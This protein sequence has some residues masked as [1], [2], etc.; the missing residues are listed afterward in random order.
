MEYFV[1]NYEIGRIHVRPD[2]GGY[3]YPERLWRPYGVNSY[4]KLQQGR[5]SFGWN[6]IPGELYHAWAPLNAT[7]W[8]EEFRE[9]FAHW[10]LAVFAPHDLEHTH[11]MVPV[12]FTFTGIGSDYFDNAL[13]LHKIVN[14][15]DCIFVAFDTHLTGERH[16]AEHRQG[17]S[18]ANFYKSIDIMDD[19]QCN[20]R[21]DFF[22]EM[23]EELAFNVLQITSFLCQRFGLPKMPLC[24][25]LG[26][27][28]GG[29]YAHQIALQ[30][31]HCFG[32]VGGA[33][34]PDI[35]LYRGPYDLA[36]RVPNWLADTAKKVL[37]KINTPIVP[38][39]LASFA[40]ALRA[41]DRSPFNGPPVNPST[42]FHFIVGTRDYAF[43]AQEVVNTC[44]ALP[45]NI[46]G[47]I[48][49][50]GTHTPCEVGNAGKLTAVGQGMLDYLAHVI[51]INR[52]Y[53][54]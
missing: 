14:E 8:G 2:N 15:L 9:K 5:D 48:A 31:P 21:N 30:T 11:R 6:G 46:Y 19:K 12:V 49:E 38:P 16:L 25:T 24:Y 41:I 17:N 22:R 20:M 53:S 47:H 40:K 4:F 33:A 27:S 35:M 50:G 34:A 54:N 1:N 18:E 29:F 13:Y 3:V 44:A 45:Y 51:H 43:N 39:Q 23:N 32:C 28:L 10:R 37:K 26:F 52:H 36:R 42:E 7:A